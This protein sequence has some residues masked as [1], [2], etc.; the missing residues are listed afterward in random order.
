MSKEER[1][2]GGD[3]PKRSRE[4][5]G[6]SHKERGREKK[7]KKKSGKRSR[8]GSR[9]RDRRCVRAAACELSR[10]RKR[11]ALIF[12]AFGCRNTDCL[13]PRPYS[14]KSGPCPVLV[15]DEIQPSCMTTNPCKANEYLSVA[16]KR[17]QLLLPA[18]GPA[19]LVGLGVTSLLQL[20][21]T[22]TSWFLSSLSLV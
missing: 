13:V 22:A 19:F 17:R 6:G 18:P 3:G 7:S 5:D 15:N 16:K 10:K 14:V 9:H 21:F 11:R 20:H 1:E 12:S 4:K 8:S 2:H